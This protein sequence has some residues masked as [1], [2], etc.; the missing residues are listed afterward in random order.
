MSPWGVTSDRGGWYAWPTITHNKMRPKLRNSNRNQFRIKICSEPFPSKIKAHVAVCHYM[1]N[2]IECKE[3]LKLLTGTYSLQWENIVD[4]INML[5]WFVNVLPK[6][7]VKNET[8]RF[9]IGAALCR[10]CK[11]GV[12]R[13]PKWPYIDDSVIEG[14]HDKS[15]TC[16]CGFRRDINDKSIMGM[17]LEKAFVAA[18]DNLLFGVIM[19]C[20]IFFE[21]FIIGYQNL[22]HPVNIAEEQHSS[23]EEMGDSDFILETSDNEHICES[24]DSDA[25]TPPLSKKAKKQ[26]HDPCLLQLL[27]PNTV[28]HSISNPAHDYTFISNA[29]IVPDIPSQH[30]L[31]GIPTKSKRRTSTPGHIQPPPTPTTTPLPS[32]RTFPL[33]PQS[34]V[35]VTVPKPIQPPRTPTTTPIPSMPAPPLY[36]HSLSPPMTTTISS[37]SI[38]TTTTSTTA[39]YRSPWIHTNH[40]QQRNMNHDTSTDS[41]DI[42]TICYQQNRKFYLR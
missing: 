22:V 25:H 6:L 33:S 31:E 37:S 3:S 27:Q 5:K 28:G 21:Y 16:Y 2:E 14:I 12:P 11:L 1:F 18:S 4:E 26:R 7:L 35:R 8:T 36:Q 32:M 20:T 34:T 40:V 13:E 9:C 17:A 19:D 15:L 29:R 30:R 10:L 42:L 38:T 23:T 39:K 41:F 24:H